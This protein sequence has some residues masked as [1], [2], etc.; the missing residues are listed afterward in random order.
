MNAVWETLLETQHERVDRFPL[1]GG[2]LV[3]TIWHRPSAGLGVPEQSG[4]DVV[5]VPRSIFDLDH[6]YV[7]PEDMIS[8][9]VHVAPRHTQGQIIPWRGPLD[10]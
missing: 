2:W 6:P 1:H 4:H 5:F 8:E 7:A 9:P 3:R 10:G